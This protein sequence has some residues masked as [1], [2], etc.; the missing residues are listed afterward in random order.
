[1][2]IRSMDD[3][4]KKLADNV[5]ALGYPKT[6]VDQGWI[7]GVWYCGT[8]YQKAIYYGQYPQTFVKR[9]KAM[10]P[11]ESMLHL[12]CGRCHID[13]AL[14]VDLKLLPEVDLVGNAE[15][16]LPLEGGTFDVIL[17]DPPYS[18][19]DSTRYGVPRL[20]NARKVMTESSRL[21]VPGGWLLWLDEKYP[22]FKKKEWALRGVIAVISGAGRRTRVLSMFQ[23]PGTT[24]EPSKG[25]HNGQLRLQA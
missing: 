22:T 2:G 19:E 7:Y 5:N 8:A 20:V 18:E 1:M 11:E 10:F 21:L 14:N 3:D 9:V 25:D 24:W 12:C 13:G 15:G 4:L 23:R 6:I 17:I 16:P